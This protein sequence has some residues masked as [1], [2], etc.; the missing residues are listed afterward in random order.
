MVYPKEILNRLRWDQG[1]SLEEATIWYVHRGAPGDVATV[2]G[3]DV[4]A[5]E[6]G[7]M[8]VGEASIPYHRIIRIEYRGKVV[9]DKELERRQGRK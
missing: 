3:S 7:F 9:F 2:P 4:A 5:L 8:Q 6:K 1:E